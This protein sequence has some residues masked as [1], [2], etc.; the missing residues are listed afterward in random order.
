ME[1]IKSVGLWLCEGGR[2]HSICEHGNEGGFVDFEFPWDCEVGVPP[3][4]VEFGEC[5]SGLTYPGG[6]VCVGGAVLS[7]VDSQ[8]SGL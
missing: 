8:V 2:L 4:E 3:E 1:S 7:D 6:D 5:C